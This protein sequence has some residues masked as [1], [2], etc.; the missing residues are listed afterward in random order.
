MSGQ[1]VTQVS[2]TR[3]KLASAAQLRC[4]GLTQR[5]YVVVCIKHYQSFYS[6]TQFCLSNQPRDQ[7]AAHTL[8]M[9]QLMN[10][11]RVSLFNVFIHKSSRSFFKFTFSV[12]V[13]ADAILLN[14]SSIVIPHSFKGYFSHSKYIRMIGQ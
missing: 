10:A 9:S 8:T 5:N 7:R 11:W 2:K 4:F 12:V 14:S 6:R 1:K 13:A 3:K